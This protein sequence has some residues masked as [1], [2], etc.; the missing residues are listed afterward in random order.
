MISSKFG[1]K[2][3]TP[4]KWGKCHEKKIERGTPFRSSSTEFYR[5]FFSFFF[6]FEGQ[7]VVARPQW[8]DLILT[9]QI[10]PENCSFHSTTPPSNIFFWFISFIPCRLLIR[11]LWLSDRIMGTS[12]G[13]TCVCFFFRFF[14]W[15][16]IHST[17]FLFDVTLVRFLILFFFM[18]KNIFFIKNMIKNVIFF[19]LFFIPIFSPFPLTKKIRP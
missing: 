4:R 12:F 13:S 7:R 5:V 8:N 10:Y 14:F 18:E 11:N 17:R 19:G 16:K 2:K 15:N 6:L 9:Q 3:K 1:L